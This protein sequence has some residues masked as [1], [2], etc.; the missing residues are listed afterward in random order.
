VQFADNALHYQTGLT[1]MTQQIKSML[2]A[3]SSGS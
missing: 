2:A 1:V 3:I